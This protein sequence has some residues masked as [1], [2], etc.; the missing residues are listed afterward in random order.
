MAT[1]ARV[2]V[3]IVG[4][5]PVIGRALEVLLQ[6]AGYHTWFL[7]EPVVGKLEELLADSQLL[8]VAPALRT[9]RRKALLNIVSGPSA[10]VKIPVLELLLPDEGE[11][12]IQGQRGV[13]WPCSMEELKRAINAVL[14]ARE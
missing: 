13:L 12:H 6:A 8:L 5:D 9:E 1:A 3:V 11:E 10:P 7:S 4:G 2:K 14:L